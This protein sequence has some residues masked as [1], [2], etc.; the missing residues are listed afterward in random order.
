MSQLHIHIGQATHTIEFSGG[1]PLVDAIRQS[2]VSFAL[3]CGGNGKCGKCKVQISVNQ[4][5]PVSSE[6][7]QLLTEQELNS[8][9]RLAC[10][11]TLYSDA[12]VF[13]PQNSAEQVLST[14]RLPVYHPGS[15]FEGEHGFGV[16][17]GTTTVVVYLYNIYTG[18]QLAVCSEHN[19]QTVFGADVISR[20]QHTMTNSV[21]PLQ[22]AILS[23]LRQLMEQC[24][25]ASNISMKEVR[26]CVVAGNTTMLHLLTGQ[27]CSGIAVA[28][29]T[30]ASLFGCTASELA[31]SS[32]LHPDAKIWLP[33]CAGA[34]VGADITCALLASEM[35]NLEGT[36]L[37]VDIGTNGEMVL[38]H[39]ARYCACSTAAGPAF[40]GANIAMGMPAAQGAISSVSIE[41]TE[42]V[43]A[44]IGEASPKGICGSGL[45]DGIAVM[46]RTGVLDET[47]RILQDEDTPFARF[48]TE[49]RGQ[50][51]FTIGGSGV[52]ITQEDVRQVQLAKA[53]IAAGIRTLLKESGVTVEQVE[54]FYLAG[55][56]GNYLNLA[57]AAEIGLIPG[58]FVDKT[59]LL[60]NA[61]G[62]GAALMLL[63][64]ESLRQGQALGEA[65]VELSLSESPHFMD[66]YVDCMLFE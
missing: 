48:V 35:S 50:P 21:E 6:E 49:Y 57:S 42:V 22:T 55:G 64:R 18:E 13:L 39:N 24:C 28:P 27:D 43:C 56:F 25:N 44:T 1:L 29:F 47:G 15:A 40:E 53:A 61:A 4:P 38:H 11:T 66:Q 41:G 31:A 46:L 51:A 33:R 52:L 16:D 23:Q 2:G 17:I 62:M 20:I 36:A 37:L 26:A 10:E 54:R 7:R 9:I 45:V 8:G 12:E 32:G 34:Y 60:G 14:G 3:P 59:T 63:S 58:S 30:P 65:I 5:L 19:A